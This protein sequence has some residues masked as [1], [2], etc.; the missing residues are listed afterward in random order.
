MKISNDIPIKSR[1][2]RIWG[3]RTY[4]YHQVLGDRLDASQVE[5]R[6]HTD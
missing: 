5:P 1:I 4:F 3:D 6:K 2:M